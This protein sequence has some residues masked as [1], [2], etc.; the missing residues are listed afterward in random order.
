MCAITRKPTSS[1]EL[2]D[3][4]TRSSSQAGE[5]DLFGQ[6]LAPASPSV[7]LAKGKPKMT[8]GISGRTGFGSFASAALSESLASKLF[9]LL[10]LDG[11]M[12]LRQSWKRKRTPLGR[13]PWEHTVSAPRTDDSA[14]GLLPTL[15]ARDSRSLKGARDR[16]KRVGS[17]SLS[18][19]LLLRGL[20]TTP[21]SAA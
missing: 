8:R 1:Q 3:G 17:A 12:S 5:T 6:A 7:R 13:L 2:G 15:T 19:L 21:R 9:A 10:A 4:P 18:H 11:S 16:P 20:R 14:S